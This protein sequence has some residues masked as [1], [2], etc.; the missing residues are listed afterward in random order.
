MSSIDFDGDSDENN[1]EWSTKIINIVK[2]PP[3]SRT[4][5]EC[6]IVAGFLQVF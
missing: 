6:R 3:G 4:V 1:R 2:K 5:N